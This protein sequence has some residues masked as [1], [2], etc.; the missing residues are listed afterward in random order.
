LQTY[1]TPEAFSFDLSVLFFIVILIG[2]RGSILGPLLGTV[3]LTF[4][5]EFAAPLAAWSTFLYAILLLAVVL[6]APGGIAALLDLKNGRPQES[7]RAIEGVDLNV[8]PARIYGLI[9]PNGS[10]KTTMINV[11]SGYY[12]PQSGPVILGGAELEPA[13]RK[14]A[15]VMVSRAR[16]RRRALWVRARSPRMS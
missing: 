12:R 9:G 5:P 15:S 11:I 13:D 14:P 2:G 8:E 1:I 4:L 6:V 7:N 3:I 10:G 16:F